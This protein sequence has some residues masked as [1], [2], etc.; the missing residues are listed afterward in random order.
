MER[1]QDST[2]KEIMQKGVNY[3]SNYA[4]RFEKDMQKEKRITNLLIFALIAITIIFTFCSLDPILLNKISEFFINIDKEKLSDFLS[5][6][7]IILALISLYMN[8]TNGRD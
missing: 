4:R 3:M 2:S 1:N 7:A 8:C 6:L 5:S